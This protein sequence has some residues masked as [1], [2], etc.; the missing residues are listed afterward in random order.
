ML[1]WV[2]C[3][4]KTL[5][6]FVSIAAEPGRRRAK[7]RHK[8][9][10]KAMPQTAVNKDTG[11]M[12]AAAFCCSSTRCSQPAAP[13]IQAVCWVMQSKSGSVS[14]VALE[15]HRCLVTCSLTNVVP[16]LMSKLRRDR[17]VR[18]IDLEL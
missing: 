10:R 18:G 9:A 1:V 13:F 14:S 6:F 8:K 11:T 17:Q 12:L 2:K 7:P 16:A 3:K 5:T 4:F 15:L